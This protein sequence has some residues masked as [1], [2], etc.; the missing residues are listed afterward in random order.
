MQLSASSKVAYTSLQTT[1]PLATIYIL[2]KWQIFY[3]VVYQR[4][5]NVLRSLVMSSLQIY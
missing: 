3:T 2:N 5:E 4:A 1:E